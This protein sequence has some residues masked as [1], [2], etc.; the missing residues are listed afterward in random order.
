MNNLM[1]ISLFGIAGGLAIGLQAPLA[2]IISQR[3]GIFESVFIIH[4]GGLVAVLAILLL[5]KGGNLG[6]WQ[7]VP[8][9]ALLGGTLGVILISAQVYI[10]PT[11]GVAATITLIIAGQLLMAT[12]IDHFGLL[13]IEAIALTWKRLLGLS[14]VLVGVWLT[15]RN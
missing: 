3:I 14:I 4:L 9:Y 13:E 15:V 6:Q 11:I 7:T 12:C 5:A 10:I 1:F 8:W 2:A